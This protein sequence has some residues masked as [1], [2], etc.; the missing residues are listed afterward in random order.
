LNRIPTPAQVVAGDPAAGISARLYLDRLPDIYRQQAI[1]DIQQFKTMM[2][3][4]AGGGAIMGVMWMQMFVFGAPMF[5][6]YP[7]AEPAVRDG[8][9]L[10]VEVRYDRKRLNLNFEAVLT[11]KADSE[12]SKLTA[13]ITPH[14]S[15]FPQMLGSDLAARG[16]VR[17]TIPEGVRKIFIPQIE[18]GLGQIPQADPVWGALAAKIGESLLPTF[19]E[20]EID[21]AGG[22]SG[23]GKNDRYGI[24]AGLRLKD[25][26]GVETALRDAVKA[27]P[28]DA[29]AIFKL[30]AATIGGVKVHQILPPPLP[31]P[32]KSL[33]GESTIHIAF[34]PDGVVAAFGD[35]A[36]ATLGAG[37]TAKPQVIA[38][39]FIEASGRKLVSLVTKIDAEA[40]KKF[41]AF[42]GTELDRIPLME[43]AVEGGSALKVR[44]GNGFTTMIPAMGWFMFSAAPMRPAPV[45][46][47]A[48][49]PVLAP[50]IK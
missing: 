27:L 34:R 20:G 39:T 32:A 28:K 36:P 47:P 49:A 5:Q 46:V 38:Q 17:G 29:Q 7:L 10:T 40:G 13:A 21:F 19:R 42:L 25:A 45:A 44:Y 48:A 16:I 41:K 8:Q 11:A 43:M 6:L 24:V 2:T 22:L 12:L 30:D 9:E 31:E 33:F 15:L 23:P 35:G 50:P 3:G 37:L 4:N 26:A 14:T 1:A 18:A